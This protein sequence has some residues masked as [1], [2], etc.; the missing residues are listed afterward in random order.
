MGLTEAVF[1]FPVILSVGFLLCVFS[2][3]DLLKLRR[4]FQ[5]LY[6]IKDPNKEILTDTHIT[7]IAPVWL[8]PL[9]SIHNQ[10][11]KFIIFLI[12]LFIFSITV[13]LIFL[14][15]G[16]WGMGAEISVFEKWFYSGLYL[17]SLMPF[18]YGSW[19]VKNDLRH[20]Y[21]SIRPG[22]A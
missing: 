4:I 17:I 10:K 14:G 7:Y 1:L 15:W 2:F 20:Y 22:P 16:M 5:R 3:C 21:D 19:L 6:Q 18:I 13:C 8:E 9:D 11:I 12:P